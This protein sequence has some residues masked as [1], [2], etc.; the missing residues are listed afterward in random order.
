MFLVQPCDRD[1]PAQLSRI[2]RPLR[3][4]AK[5]AGELNA[6]TQICAVTPLTTRNAAGTDRAPSLPNVEGCSFDQRSVGNDWLVHEPHS[7]IRLVTG[8]DGTIR[9]VDEFDAEISAISAVDDEVWHVP[10]KSS[11]AK[12]DR[13]LSAALI[14]RRE[15]D[16]YF[17]K[18][19]HRFDGLFQR[20]FCNAPLPCYVE[21]SP[22]SHGGWN[23]M[24]AGSSVTHSC[25]SPSSSEH[26]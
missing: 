13:R 6:V 19:W 8:I 21:Y 11:F 22:L 26:S 9:P 23:M 4:S 25:F 1:F 14:S 24:S 20:G 12:P 15:C 16:E 17:C 5:L 10:R 18:A 2:S 7:C 3:S